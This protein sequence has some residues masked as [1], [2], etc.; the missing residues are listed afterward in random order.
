VSKLEALDK[1]L[2]A[3]EKRLQKHTT[4]LQQEVKFGVASA[5]AQADSVRALFTGYALATR[6]QR[7]TKAVETVKA[8]VKASEKRTEAIAKAS[9]PAPKPPPIKRSFKRPK[10][11]NQIQQ[12]VQRQR[13]LD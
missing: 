2:K 12:Q 3:L 4:Q 6:G 13:L 11:W 8:I 10:S 1:D 7:P 5:K 9:P